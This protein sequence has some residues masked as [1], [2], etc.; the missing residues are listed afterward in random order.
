MAT[1]MMTR[2]ATL[3]ETEGK[4]KLAL[5][6]IKTYKNE[7]SQ[8]LGERADSEEEIKKVNQKVLDLKG[9]LAE[10]HIDNMDLLDQRNRLQE[11]VNS[12][13]SCND[14]YLWSLGRITELE[15]DLNEAHIK[16]V[17]LEHTIQLYDSGNTHNLY[18]ELVG[19]GH[20]SLIG[21][22][23]S[24][25]LLLKT[26]S[27]N[28]LKRYSKVCR[29]IK[30]IEF[31]LSR[32]NKIKLLKNN[33][34]KLVAEHRDLLVELDTCSEQL[35]STKV[36]YEKHTLDLKAKITTLQ[37]R[38]SQMSLEYEQDTRDY[39]LKYDEIAKVG[40]GVRLYNKLPSS[41]MDLPQQKFKLVVKDHLIKRGY[42][43]ID[44]YIM[45]KKSWD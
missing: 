22:K 15:S 14:T 18:S 5:L 36:L 17:S 8:L 19:S 44:D 13:S 4:L 39:I 41:V 20:Q 26:R 3:K 31:N 45:D 37:D 1:T 27:H 16:I 12:F 25:I 35:I 33:N 23:R 28:K 10:L 7:N 30:K 32:Y 42:Y 11:E 34:N 2:K 24:R 43:K 29:L 9:E 6:E 40:L 21:L 38:L